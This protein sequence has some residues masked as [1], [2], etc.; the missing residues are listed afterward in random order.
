M[1]PAPRRL[2]KEYSGNIFSEFHYFLKNKKCKVYEAPFDVRLVKNKNNV[3]HFTLCSSTAHLPL[4]YRRLFV[5]Y[6][7]LYFYISE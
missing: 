1:S 3:N 7:A 5:K 6:E 4:I 2:H